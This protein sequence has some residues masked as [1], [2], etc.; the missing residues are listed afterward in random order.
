MSS[1][2]RT[3]HA[4][5]LVLTACSALASL[6]LLATAPVAAVST[7]SFVLDD[8]A[9]FGMG[10]L[11]HVAVRSDGRVVPAIGFDRVALPEDVGLV[12]CAALGS[13]G[14]IYLGTGE[15]GRIYRVRGENVELFA[16]TGQ[17][18]VSALTLGAGGTLYA[19]TL[20]EARIYAL[21]TAA[22]APVTPREL[23]RPAPTD[24]SA[25]AEHIWDLAFDASHHRLFA[26]TGPE[27]RVYAIDTANGN[28]SVYFDSL[29]EHVMALAL[30]PD[31]V[32]YAGTTD[33]ALVL[34]ITAANTATV[35]EDF[36]GNEITALAL[37]D[38][39]LAVAAN[40]FPEAPAVSGGSTKRSA[41][42][43]RSARPRPGKALVYRV[44]ADGRSE[45]I[46]SQDDAHV[47]RLEWGSS[48]ELYA[49]L[50]NE[51]R[52]VRIESDRSSSIWADV[53]ERQV[54]AM[55]IGGSA[56]FFATGD[57]AAMYRV[58]GASPSGASW[59]SKVLDGEFRSR[60]G[61]LDWRGHGA[62]RFST[63]SGNTARP[64]AT[65]SDWSAEITSPGPIRSAAGRFLQ[66]RAVFPDG[67]LDAELRSVTA[68]YLPENQRPV[69]S[70]VGIKRAPSKREVDPS[71]P[72]SPSSAMPLG[73]SL[74]NPDGDRTRYRLRYRG[75][76]QTVWRSMLEEHETL[77]AT[78]YTWETSALPDGYYVVEVEASDELSNPSDLVLRSNASSESI[79]IDNHAPTVTVSASGTTVRGEAVDTLGPIMR[80]EIAVDGGDFHLLF[81]VDDLFDAARE[82]FEVDAA[83]LGIAAGAHII[84][85]RAFDA[86]G[87]Q[88]SAEVTVTIAAAAARRPTR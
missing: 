12:W 30:A 5:V 8:A 45:R 13:D 60:W 40:E 29:A 25:A 28:A 59:I 80:L 18:M 14:A 3:R 62:L 74:D 79:L 78:E 88:G 33:E 69:V 6:A 36:P 47:T 51:G 83:T 16:E 86:A 38:G 75:E 10:E 77:S 41:T 21:D 50:G 11:D 64:D 43:G 53:D 65:W 73:W 24:G 87:N 42:A 2:S 19:G 39:V 44:G 66:I 52:V 82:R 35:V 72:P 37:R 49:A 31:G 76:A 57:G 63:R 15:T 4:R 32:L 81:P 26:A 17:L 20:P 67:A 27:G 7:R 84:A 46:H 48:G 22:A 54:L 71:M 56:P 55:S 85:V 9:S 68:Y 70:A 34:R 61:G 58:T 23:S 1:S